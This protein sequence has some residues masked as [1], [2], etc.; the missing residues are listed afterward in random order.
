MIT[1]YVDGMTIAIEDG[2]TVLDAVRAAGFDVPTLC[3]HDQIDASANCRL[4]TVEVDLRI[5]RT[6][7][8]GE[9]E[10]YSLYLPLDSAPHVVRT[11]P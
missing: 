1:V 3:Y 6:D 4:C 9:I 11:R 10:T 5:T 7:D 8:R 2:A